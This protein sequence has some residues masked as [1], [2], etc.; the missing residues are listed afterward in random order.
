MSCC[1]NVSLSLD[2]KIIMAIDYFS[3]GRGVLAIIHSTLPRYQ[4]QPIYSLQEEI[5]WRVS[6]LTAGYFIVLSVGQTQK[7]TLLL[8]WMETVFN[9]TLPFTLFQFGLVN[10]KL[11]HNVFVITVHIMPFHIMFLSAVHSSWIF[12]PV[13]RMSTC[14][15]CWTKRK[16]KELKWT[17][18]SFAPNLLQ[19][20]TKGN[21][22]NIEDDHS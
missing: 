4:N 11:F 3:C 16:G 15:G 5:G 21:T 13:E 10:L 2:R 22:L 8:K 1:S 17:I 7:G 20:I 9:G 18:A 6:V 12:K 14:T 19:T